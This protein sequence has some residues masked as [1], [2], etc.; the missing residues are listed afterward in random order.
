MSGKKMIFA[1]VAIVVA[2]L[3]IVIGEKAGKQKPSDKS[4]LFFSGLAQKDIAAL[5]MSDANGKV[6]I[7]RKGDIWILGNAGAKSATPANPILGDTAPAVADAHEFQADSASLVAVLEKIVAI[8]KDQLISTNVEKQSLFEVDSAKGILVDVFDQTGKSRGSFRL[9]KNGPDYSSCYLRMT[10]SNEVYMVGGN[11][12]YSF[13]TDN[14]RWRDKTIIKFDQNTA[15]NIA[16][17]KK[18]GSKIVLGKD[19]TWSIKEPIQSPAKVS[20][21]Q[22]ILSGLS[23]MTAA[24]F[25]T[26]TQDSPSAG[27]GSPELAVAITLNNN[28]VKSVIFGNKNGSSQYYVKTDGKPHVY[29]VGES[30]FN[31]FNVA[32]D[33]LKEVPP[34]PAADSAAAVAPV[35]APAVKEMAKT[36]AK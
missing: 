17:M 15:S 12:R 36:K 4:L 10:G 1:V 27:F 21:I 28:T 2:I 7:Q 16:I 25:D 35:T 20:E 24:D 23:R 26:L 14:K 13:F 32:V 34:P 11:I 22:T 29:L 19:S 30:E 6:R 9:G 18:D 3:V 31:K 5:E 8:K 33:Q